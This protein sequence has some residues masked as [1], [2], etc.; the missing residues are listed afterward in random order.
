M[1][2]TTPGHLGGNL[3]NLR[4]I[5]VPTDFGPGSEEALG[6]ALELARE[7]GAEV[8]LT[9]AYEIPVVGFP[10]GTLVATAELATRVLEAAHEGLEKAARAHEGEGVRIRTVAK[11]GAAASAIVETADEVGADL[12]IMSTHGRH[13]LPRAL[14]GS[15]AEKVVR[16]AHCPVLTVRAAA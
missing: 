7:L 10:D 3:G 12:V 4:T 15:V 6:Y 14:L 13:G 8:V 11:E 1:T 2:A 16:T 5:L 9:H